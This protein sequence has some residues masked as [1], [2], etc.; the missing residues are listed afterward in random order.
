MPAFDIAVDL[1]TPEVDENK[2]PENLAKALLKHKM[3]KVQKS[4]SRKDQKLRKVLDKKE[5]SKKSTKQEK[6]DKKKEPDQKIETTA[7][8][9]SPDSADNEQPKESKSREK[10]SKKEKHD[11]P[12]KESPDQEL[13][14]EYTATQAYTLATNLINHYFGDNVDVA[15]DIKKELLE[16][17]LK[18]DWKSAQETYQGVHT[19]LNRQKYKAEAENRPDF[20]GILNYLLKD[21]PTAKKLIVKKSTDKNSKHDWITDWFKALILLST[22]QKSP[23][24]DSAVICSINSLITCSMADFEQSIPLLYLDSKLNDFVSDA[25]TVADDLSIDKL[26]LL[27]IKIITHKRGGKNVEDELIKSYQ[28]GSAEAALLL[29]QMYHEGVFAKRSDENALSILDELVH[30]DKECKIQRGLLINTIAKDSKQKEDYLSLFYAMYLQSLEKSKASEPTAILLELLSDID[31]TLKSLIKEGTLNSQQDLRIKISDII[32]K[33]GTNETLLSL[34]EKNDDIALALCNVIASANQ[35]E[36]LKNFDKKYAKIRELA[37]TIDQKKELLS[38]TICLVCNLITKYLEPAQ[39][40]ELDKKLALVFEQCHTSDDIIKETY[41]ICQNTLQTKS[42]TVDELMAILLCLQ[43]DFQQ[44]NEIIKNYTNQGKIWSYWYC[45][46]IKHAVLHPSDDRDRVILQC[47]GRA[48]S[49]PFAEYDTLKDLYSY[50]PA[51]V[52][53]LKEKATVDIEA[54]PLLAR[55]ALIFG[56]DIV[57]IDREMAKKYFI[58]DHERH[59]GTYSSIFLADLY[60]EGT[61]TVIP[62]SLT[63][64]LNIVQQLIDSGS[65]NIACPF[66]LKI[67]Q[68]AEM[69]GD[70]I[71]FVRS[72]CLSI[73]VSEKVSEDQAILQVLLGIT[74]R[75]KNVA[76]DDDNRC[77]LMALINLLVSTGAY[78]SLLRTAKKNHEI[79]LELKEVVTILKRNGT[80]RDWYGEALALCNNNE[81]DTQMKSVPA[82]TLEDLRTQFNKGSVS[83]GLKLAKRYISEN[84]QSLTQ[85]FD[86]IQQIAK[87]NIKK[88][89][90]ENDEIYKLLDPILHRAADK[91]D[92]M[93]G[94]HATTVLIVKSAQDEQIGVC[95]FGL[96]SLIDLIKFAQNRKQ[97]LQE[98]FQS[99]CLFDELDPLTKKNARIKSLIDD[100]RSILAMG[101]EQK[102]NSGSNQRTIPTLADV[103]KHS[104]IIQRLLIHYLGRNDETEMLC[105]ELAVECKFPQTLDDFYNR[106][107]T[108]VSKK[109]NSK[110]QPVLMAILDALRSKTADKRIAHWLDAIIIF[111]TEPETEQR[112]NDILTLLQSALFCPHTCYDSALKSLL[113]YDQGFVEFLQK[114]AQ[115]NETAAIVFLRFNYI[116]GDAEFNRTSLDAIEESHNRGIIPASIWLA[117]NKVASEKTPDSLH[118]AL[119]I[120]QNIIATQKMYDVPLMAQLGNMQKIANA[121]NDLVNKLHITY[122]VIALACKHNNDRFAFT[123]LLEAEDIIQAIAKS[124]TKQDVANLFISS[125]AYNAVLLRAN[126]EVFI[127]KALGDIIGTLILECQQSP[128]YY[129]D[130][131]VIAAHSC[132]ANIDQFGKLFV[133][134][135]Q[136]FLIRENVAS[137][138]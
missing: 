18:K 89:K 10:K 32:S 66:L 74:D 126:D 75:C 63:N 31:T 17:S 11:K 1:S 96:S 59:K 125:G 54:Q 5:Q 36:K 65:V 40:K 116:L 13:Q 51:L 105:G 9:T 98:I 55:I 99:S 79:A 81:A 108:I 122:L 47:I 123:K 23:D 29:A 38:N 87:K 104:A 24:R 53:F 39:A 68:K 134:G 101:S 25:A 84:E 2:S 7:K 20:M 3:Q 138:S 30:Q 49:V 22:D 77:Y 58:E 86:I 112:N 35:L 37:A 137:S 16:L 71:P 60:I 15:A 8:E 110:D 73:I 62:Q 21:F 50:P 34:A 43:G 45:A 131:I 56:C 57:G 80:Y 67:S 135:K 4:L 124:N 85:A 121:N 28:Q 88:T 130:G 114:L 95:E 97:E 12:C 129:E 132:G 92:F 133:E 78:K 111:A 6:Q 90:E 14:P 93:L 19:V 46:M 48:L 100:I 69:L 94:I 102:S 106:V 64:A 107:Y 103:H 52:S 91:E 83:A 33:V 120:L 119:K 72:I 118:N 76:S 117:E 127:A 82:P 41:K 128:D 70:T 115:H 113:M 27:R 61:K 136:C 42:Q 26:R 109:I 44:A